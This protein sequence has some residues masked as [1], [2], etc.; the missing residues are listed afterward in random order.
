MVE[1]FFF[2]FIKPSYYV[3]YLSRMKVSKAANNAD[4]DPNKMINLLFVISNP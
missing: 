3:E 1:F 2:F 4:I